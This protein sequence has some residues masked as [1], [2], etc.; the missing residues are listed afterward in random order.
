IYLIN[1]I[2]NKY[3]QRH[4]KGLDCP[5]F[6]IRVTNSNL[7]TKTINYINTGNLY[8]ELPIV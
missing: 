2:V 7:T 6:I 4:L 5:T 3:N 8:N 1:T